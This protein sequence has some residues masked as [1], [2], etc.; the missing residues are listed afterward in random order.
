MPRVFYDEATKASIMKAAADARAAGKT[1]NDAHDSAKAAG[2]QG[3]T[4]GII[5]LLRASGKRKAKTGRKPGRPVGSGKRKMKRKG[6]GPA[7]VKHVA[8]P[9]ASQSDDIAAMIEKLVKSRL[10]AALEKAIDALRGAK[11]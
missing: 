9:V 10:N 1:W 6:R 8:A 3:S 11:G 2:Y 4:Q 5:K 7:K